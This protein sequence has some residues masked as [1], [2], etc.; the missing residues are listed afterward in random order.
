M[1]RRATPPDLNLPCYTFCCSLV[2]VLLFGLCFLL[3]FLLV[4]KSIVFRAILEVFFCNVISE[5]IF[6][7]CSVFS[8]FFFAVVGSCFM[9]LGCFLCVII[10]QRTR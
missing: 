6:Q 1:A 5:I 2:V 10:F 7:F 3:W 8:M 4:Y 9:K